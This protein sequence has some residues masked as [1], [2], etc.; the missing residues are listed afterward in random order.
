MTESDGSRVRISEEKEL[1]AL[2]TNDFFVK[3]TVF[4][5]RLNAKKEQ[6]KS[7]KK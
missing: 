3:L 7:T 1:L 2:T 6:S 5:E 4:K